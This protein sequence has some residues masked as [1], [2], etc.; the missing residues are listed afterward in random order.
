MLFAGVFLVFLISFLAWREYTLFLHGEAREVSE[1]IAF[2][3]TM[4]DRMRCYLEPIS[5]WVGEYSS[6]ELERVGFLPAVRE[7]GDFGL[8]YEMS[9]DN[10]SVSDEVRSVISEMIS[11][12]GDGYLEGEIAAIDSALGKLSEIE[13]RL[14]GDCKNKSHA[15]G[16]MLAAIVIGAVILVI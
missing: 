13:N 1:L 11:R 10:M 4:R 16:A 14:I 6:D 2:I 8:A 9:R 7:R 3:K 5:A 15:A 12:T